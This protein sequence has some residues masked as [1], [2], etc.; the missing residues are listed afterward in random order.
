MNA[1]TVD[2]IA[3]DHAPHTKE[4]KEK[5][6]WGAP[7]G[8]TGVETMLPLLLNAVN[9]GKISLRRM[10]ELT[11]ENP[12]RVYGIKNKGFIAKGFDADLIVVDLKKERKIRRREL[13]CR[14]K[15]SPFEGMK[16]KGLPEKT[17]IGGEII[18]DNE[19]KYFNEKF[20]G[21]EVV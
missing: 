18:W 17:I 15:W 21:K 3:T 1:G 14:C 9:E 4:E 7:S 12:C 2:L 10:V 20:R 5:D 19:R 16:L 8:V 6:Y 13:K 11:S